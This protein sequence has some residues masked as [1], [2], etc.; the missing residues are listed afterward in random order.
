MYKQQNVSSSRKETKLKEMRELEFKTCVMFRHL[1]IQLLIK[2]LFIFNIF[3]YE[4]GKLLWTKFVKDLT[5]RVLPIYLFN[6]S[7][8]IIYE[9]LLYLSDTGVSIILIL[10]H[11][12]FYTFVINFRHFDVSIIKANYYSISGLCE[13]CSSLNYY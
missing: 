10:L 5:Y 13:N 7:V 2:R 6:Y 9:D 11:V 1:S 8:T 3:T 4:I 12:C